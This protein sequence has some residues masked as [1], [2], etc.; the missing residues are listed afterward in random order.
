VPPPSSAFDV[1]EIDSAW[2]KV[3]MGQEADLVPN[4][5]A[6]GSRCFGAWIGHELVGYAWWSAK[7]EWICEVELEIAPAARE[8]Y[9]W[10]CVTLAP[11]RRKGV[12]RS[13]VTSLVAQAREEGVARLWIASVVDLAGNAI[14][15]AGFV[16]VIRFDTASRFGL[17]WLRVVPMER[18]D[19]GLLAAATEVM[20]IKPGLSVRRSKSRKH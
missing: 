8:A 15:Q 17:R 14:E 4:R 9:V 12:F 18:V 3:A 1:R 13:V 2:A 10:N 16:P 5:M 19:P 6:R 7:P 11:H 20:A